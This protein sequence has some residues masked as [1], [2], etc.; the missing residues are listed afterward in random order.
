MFSRTCLTPEQISQL[1]IINFIRETLGGTELGDDYLRIIYNFAFTHYKYMNRSVTVSTLTN[2]NKKNM[3]KA[4]VM[5]RVEADKSARR[6]Y[7]V[8]NC[9]CTKHKYPEVGSKYICSEFP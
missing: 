2:A 4:Y 9:L 1:Q 7:K 8:I 6:G 5:S 3:A